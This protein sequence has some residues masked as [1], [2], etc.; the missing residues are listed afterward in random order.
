M[1]V[2]FLLAASVLLTACSATCGSGP[3]TARLS[4][5]V[6]YLPRIALPSDAELSVSLQDVSR[7]DAPAIELARQQGPIAGQVPLPFSL[8]YDPTAVQPSHRYSVS[9]RIEHR[10][11]LLF[12]T[13]EHH[14]VQLG[15]GDPQPLRVR[16]D[17]IR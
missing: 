17:P 13:T 2:P 6:Y 5:E 16:V 15:G 1:R 9:A 7:A 8:D 4:G 10:G 14:G 11:R 3:Q 12:I